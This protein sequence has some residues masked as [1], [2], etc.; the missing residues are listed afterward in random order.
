MLMSTDGGP[1]Q[2]WK[3][4]VS[5]TDLEGDSEGCLHIFPHGS[6]KKQKFLV[7]ISP[8]IVFSY[9]ENNKQSF[10]ERRKDFI[11]INLS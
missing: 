2:Y 5:L 11:G 1:C 6:G 3:L 10:D 9:L 7:S 4:T 8:F